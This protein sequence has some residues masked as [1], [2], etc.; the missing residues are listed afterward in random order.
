MELKKKRVAGRVIKIFVFL[1]LFVALLHGVSYLVTPQREIRI[2]RTRSQQSLR[3][4]NEPQNSLDVLIFGHSGAYSAI[5]PMQMYKE[6]GIVSYVCA[7][8]LQLPWESSRW[9][10]GLLEVQSPK[11]VVF[12]TDQLFYDKQ[13]S[14][15]RNSLENIFYDT[16]P[17]FRNHANWKKWFGKNK[18]GERNLYK[19]Y[20]YNTKVK[21]YTGKKQLVPTDR[22]YKIGKRH[23]QALEE[24]YELCSERGIPL[25]LLEVPSVIVW[26]YSRYNAVNAYAQK[27][28]V[29]FTD[30]NQHL[31]EMK[32]DW[33]TDTRDKGDHLNYFGAQ[34]VTEFLG[35]DL[36]A[37]YDLPDRRADENYSAWNDDLVR[38]EKK[39]NG[40]K[41]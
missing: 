12:E 16:F 15:A 9:L 27:R 11:L 8:P 3:V 17:V 4:F 34:K 5:S 35:R 21:P 7:Q 36:K 32:F 25:M 28:G 41:S 13:T 18:K 26:D 37:N 24:V 1:A 2:A 39:I 19:G 20:Y 38:Y 6:H 40:G 23:L 33:K 30:L 31:E 10:K 22:T 29:H 14:V